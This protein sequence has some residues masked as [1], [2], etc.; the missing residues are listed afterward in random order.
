MDIYELGKSIRDDFKKLSKLTEDVIRKKEKDIELKELKFNHDDKYYINMIYNELTFPENFDVEFDVVRKEIVGNKRYN[1]LNDIWNWYKSKIS[2]LK[3]RL[4]PG[5]SI[6]ILVK[7]KTTQKYIGLVSLSAISSNLKDRDTYIGWKTDNKFK[8]LS[9]NNNLKRIDHVID[10]STCVPVQPFGWNFNGGKLLAML[11]FSEEI[12][13]IF[14]KLYKHRIAAFQ[15]MGVNG[16]SSM[17]DRCNLEKGGKSFIKYIGLS[18]GSGVTNLIPDTLYQKCIN[19]LKLLDDDVLNGTSMYKSK[20]MKLRTCMRHLN[21]D[22]SFL[23]TNARKGIYFGF[24]S[25][26]SKSFLNG[27]MDKLDKFKSI[28]SSEI[29]NKWLNRWALQRFNSRIKFKTL[30][31]NDETLVSKEK[32]EQTKKKTQQQRERRK[33]VRENGDQ[34]SLKLKRRKNNNRT[35]IRKFLNKQDG[36]SM[37][38]AEDI[39]NTISESDLESKTCSKIIEELE[40]LYK[41]KKYPDKI[42]KGY[43]LKDGWG[44]IYVI[45]NTINDKKYIGQVS[46]FR[47]KKHD[48]SGFPKRMH[49][50]ETSLNK[51]VASS[52][53]LA[54]AILK[55]GWDKFDKYPLL[56][57]KV[58]YMDHF[59]K[60][61]IKEYETHVSTKKGYNLTWGGQDQRGYNWRTG[62]QH[63]AWGKELSESHKKNI[64]EA[65]IVSKRTISDKIVNQILL[66]KHSNYT[67]N[68]VINI[69]GR[70]HDVNVSRSLI[71]NIWC[72][73]IKPLDDTKMLKNHKELVEKKRVIASN[74]SLRLE[75]SKIEEI[76]ELKFENITSEEAIEKYNNNHENEKT[77]KTVV[78][79]IWSLQLKPRFP[80]RRYT[81]L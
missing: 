17:Y 34:E 14:E 71:E 3:S 48:G 66:L 5:I 47:S 1:E 22:T 69:I 65:N 28:S 80:S 38:K 4:P 72:G 9:E 10:I 63:H 35:H 32:Q 31:Y 78:Y 24:T 60:K 25:D 13:N 76:Y 18:K 53:V 49:E 56:E 16:K 41:F 7:E 44:T 21:I 36:I 12:Q 43:H 40:K 39:I 55:Y 30:K 33:R 15:T 61:F 51:T 50:H 57:C 58:E 46:H 81:E 2:S 68:E 64:S 19:Y 73:K 74:S 37:E 11:C 45:R 70:R 75:D 52:P 62:P 29:C 8:T 27:Q 54:K 79:K 77:T 67:E 59:E 20:L 23:E 26:N 6:R 42:Y